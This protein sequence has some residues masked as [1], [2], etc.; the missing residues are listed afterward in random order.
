MSDYGHCSHT[1]CIKSRSAMEDLHQMGVTWRGAK[2]VANNCQQ[3]TN[4]VA[5]CPRQTKSMFNH[6]K[7]A[8]ASGGYIYKSGQ[9]HTGLTYAF[10]F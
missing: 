9:C 5:Q 3:W 2:R 4:L 10:N 7:C 6:L 1:E 8:V